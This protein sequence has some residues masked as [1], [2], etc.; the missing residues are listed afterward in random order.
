MELN[1][2]TFTYLFLRLAPFILV[3]FF[4]L[5]SIFNQDF[6]GLVYLVGLIFACFA[7]TMIGNITSPI[8]NTILGLTTNPTLMCS[9][10]L[11]IGQGTFSKIP[12][13]QSIF[14]YTFAY[15]LYIIIKNKYVL[16]NIPTLVFFPL[17]ILFDAIW[18]IGNGCYTLVDI[19]LSLTLGGVFGIMWAYIISES[20][21]T[22]LQ[23]FNKVS[24]NAECSRPAKN[25]FKC[26]VYKNGK[27]V[28]S[29]IT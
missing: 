10:V 21:M 12:L 25:T 7:T 19:A 28:T 22:K 29:N 17:I 20:G 16:Q 8:L 4:S 11:T 14:G 27:L 6:K 15:L 5:A 3:S 23:Y 24:G 1:I 13:G 18:N 2:I 26:S 9:N